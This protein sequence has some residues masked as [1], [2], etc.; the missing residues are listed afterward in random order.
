M[1]KDDRLNYLLTW[2]GVSYL[3]LSRYLPHQLEVLQNSPKRFKVLIWH[4]K[5]RKTYTAI[6]EIVKQAHARIGVYWHVFPTR[7]EAK[8]AVWRDPAMLFNIIPEE[9][10]DRRNEQEL[11]VYLKNGSIIQLKGSDDPDALRGPNPYGV[12]FDEYD[13]QKQEG[14]GVVEPIIR[15]NGG[16][17]WFVGTPRGK[18]KLYDLMNRGKSGHHEWESW[19]LR[20]STSGIM[21][22]DQLEEARKSMPDALYNQEFECAFLE[23][24]GSVF[25][26]V[27]DVMTLKAFKK[28][29][30]EHLYV[31]GVD[32]AKVKDWT[33]IRVYDR[34]TN[35][36]VFSDRFQTIEWPFQKKR[37][38]AIAKLYNNALAVIDATGIGDPI[39]DDLA[40]AGIAVEPFKI[41][42][43]S[44]KELIEKLSIWI[45]QKKMRMVEDEVAVLEYD[46]FSYDVG[47]TGKI[48][49]GARQGYHDDIVL[50]DALAVSQLQPIIGVV[51]E[52]PKTIIEEMYE[53]GITG[54]TEEEYTEWEQYQDL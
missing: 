48:R 45:E 4:R 52:K 2:E 26:G 18:A 13:T 8:D 9:L 19:L 53:R 44:K 31:M 41:S 34:S 36:L 33:V 29:I 37:I 25:R 5:A 42:E 27:R 38:Y 20:A 49:Y 23:A 11:V 35:N 50:A 15:A 54:K 32:L 40:R 51:R 43:P 6:T 14:W 47:A 3:P 10:V 7:I 1:E 16:W 39:A 12:V 30:P 24:S 21:A 46:N 28:P 22:A 17:V